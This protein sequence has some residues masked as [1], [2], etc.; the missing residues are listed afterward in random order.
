MSEQTF[1]SPGFFE[2]EI[3]ASQRQTEVVGVPAGVVGTAEKG[4]AFIPVTIGSTTDFLNKFGGTDPERFG[5]YAVQAFLANR[6]ALTYVRVLGAGANETITEIQN[7]EQNGIVINAGFKIEPK[8]SL[9]S[10]ASDSSVQFLVAKHYV[11][12]L[13]ILRSGWF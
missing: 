11:S 13:Q 1:R 4:P 3:D 2:R 6:S 9:A 5:P 10:S 12:S 8:I 7:T